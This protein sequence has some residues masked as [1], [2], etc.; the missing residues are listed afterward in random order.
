MYNFLHIYPCKS[1][2]MYSFS[3]DN[4]FNCESIK[5]EQQR[6]DK[7][8]FT[9]CACNLGFSFSPY[10]NYLWV[11]TNVDVVLNEPPSGGFLMGVIY[12][13]KRLLQQN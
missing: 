13:W 1:W 3:V 8:D 10:I 4:Y 6:G 12:E 5:K 7:Y 11:W 2:E 9:R